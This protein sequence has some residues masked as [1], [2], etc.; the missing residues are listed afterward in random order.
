M[1]QSLRCDVASMIFVDGQ[2]VTV[3]TPKGKKILQT[4]PAIISSFDAY[5]LDGKCVHVLMLLIV[6]HIVDDLSNKYLC[7]CFGQY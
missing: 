2:V 6:I 1:L 3:G 4:H 5:F 7:A